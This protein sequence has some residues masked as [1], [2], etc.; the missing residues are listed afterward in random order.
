M[1]TI[2]F[3]KEE[4]PFTYL[5]FGVGYD[6][7][8]D[9]LFFS[10]E[11]FRSLTLAEIKAVLAHEYAHKIFFGVDLDMTDK[12]EEFLAD[13]FAGA[14]VGYDNTISMLRKVTRM[15]GIAITQEGARH[16]STLRRIRRLEEIRDE[17][18]S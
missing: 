4:L 18:I 15:N 2:I 6:G 3:S 12:E 9:N 10:R 16:P 1:K 17:Q 5:G 7:K 13:H 8:Y 14:R 11:L